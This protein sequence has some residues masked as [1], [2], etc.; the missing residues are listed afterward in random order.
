MESSSLLRC[1]GKVV[2]VLSSVSLRPFR[3]HFLPT[4]SSLPFSA[5]LQS[6]R[7]L[8][9]SARVLRQPLSP[10]WLCAGSVSCE[11]VAQSAWGRLCARDTA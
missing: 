1:V 3:L 6:R 10:R 4:F 11:H 8:L 9:L 7:K 2:V 5:A